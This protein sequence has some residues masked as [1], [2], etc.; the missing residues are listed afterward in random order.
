[1]DSDLI[2]ISLGSNIGDQFKNLEKAILEIQ[3]VCGSLSSASSLYETEPWGTFA[4]DP[5]LNQVIAVESPHEPPILLNLFLE[6][7]KK[8]GRIRTVRNAPRIIDIDILLYGSKI[9]L[10][11][12]IHI[13]HPRMHLRKFILIPMTEIAPDLIHPVF[14][15]SM[16]ELLNKCTDS[17]FV[18]KLRTHEIKP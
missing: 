7:E 18:K 5:F 8:M 12:S 9:I 1:M 4:Q 2:Y 6:I 15:Q 13:P 11:E 16:K 14:N 17:S 3:S 10:N